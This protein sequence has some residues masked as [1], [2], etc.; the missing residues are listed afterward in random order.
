VTFTI[1]SK[2]AYLIG[3]IIGD[4]YIPNATKSKKSNS[5]DYQIRID[6]ADQKHLIFLSKIIKSI[7]NT[8]ST[9]KIPKQ[10]GNRKP[11][12]SFQFRNKA[13][14]KFL[15]EELK[16]PK[17]AKSK[18]VNI[19][20]KIKKSSITI[21]RYFLAGYFDSDGGFRQNSIG[22]TTASKQMQTDVSKL[23]EELKLTH[24]TEKW[25]NKKYNQEYYGITINK[26]KIDTFL[27]TIPLQNQEKTGRIKKR[28]NAEL[29][30][31]SNPTWNLN[32]ESKLRYR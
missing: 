7:I 21:R 11:R 15:T 31:W 3:F 20:Y 28:F 1:N 16:I 17:G 30:E 19:P 27:N 23:L 26:K 12:L 2:I 22:F 14:F 5:P 24:Y 8:K 6:I 10:R 9:P 4:G 18:H 29:P 25:I 13:F 32:K